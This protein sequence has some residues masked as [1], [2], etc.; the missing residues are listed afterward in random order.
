MH[1]FV[2]KINELSIRSNDDEL[3]PKISP[4]T[5]AR[6]FGVKVKNT[7]AL[8]LEETRFLR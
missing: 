2:V 4:A 6:T 7:A 5:T 8:E 3:P 1:C